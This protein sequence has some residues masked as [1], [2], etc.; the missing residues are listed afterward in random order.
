MI[1]KMIGMHVSMEA[2][3]T[4]VLSRIVNRSGLQPALYDNDGQLHMANGWLLRFR[5]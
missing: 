4:S 3:H 2:A 1:P 5:T